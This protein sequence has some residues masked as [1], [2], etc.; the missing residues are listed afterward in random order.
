MCTWW[1]IKA[2]NR[3]FFLKKKS[4]NGV[5]PIKNLCIQFGV[6]NAVGF[7]D[8]AGIKAVHSA[9]LVSTNLL[10]VSTHWPEMQTITQMQRSYCCFKKRTN[11]Q[12]TLSKQ[13]IASAGLHLSLGR[14]A[15]RSELALC[16]RA[17]WFFWVLVQYPSGNVGQ[18]LQHKALDFFGRDD[19]HSPGAPWCAGSCSSISFESCFAGE[20]GWCWTWGL[21][22]WRA[23]C[24][25]PGQVGNLRLAVCFVCLIRTTCTLSP[26]KTKTKIL[27]REVV[28]S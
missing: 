19:M 11:T 1:K 25:W 23:V 14:S 20:Q 5:T 26:Y 7:S 6:L 9:A 17:K 8:S 3:G 16:H 15:L 12:T 28:L 2:T 13:S 24:T 22:S 27:S 10:S 21:G 18:L 4:K